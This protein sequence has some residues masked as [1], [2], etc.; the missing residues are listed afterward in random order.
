MAKKPFIPSIYISKLLLGFFEVERA[1][2]RF[3]PLIKERSILFPFFS[4]FL[5]T[6]GLVEEHSGLGL[7]QRHSTHRRGRDEGYSES[8][9][10]HYKIYL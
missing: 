10:T 5:L 2:C 1:A 9:F 6:Q 7:L 8:C 3:L 4:L